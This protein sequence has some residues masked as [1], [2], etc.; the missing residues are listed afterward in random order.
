[1]ESWLTPPEFC[2]L[3]AAF[4]PV[5]LDPCAAR[6][7][8]VQARRRIYAPR[9]GDGGGGLG[10][11]SWGNLAAGRLIF[12]NPPW[13]GSQPLRAWGAKI[14]S[15][16]E[17]AKVERRPFELIALLPGNTDTGWYQDLF[18]LAVCV[19]ALRGRLC[20]RR[21]GDDRASP[22]RFASHVFYFGKRAA[23]FMRAF[24]GAGI[25]LR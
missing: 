23:K 11:P 6:G 22:A 8:F 15:E 3:L 18:P 10:W 5:Y 24:D 9:A 19:L 7:Q 14:R 17:R 20:Y 4:G 2:D 21:A 25:W 13:E 12:V 16:V 1:M